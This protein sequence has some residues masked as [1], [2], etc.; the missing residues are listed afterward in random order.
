MFKPVIKKILNAI[1]ERIGLRLIKSSSVSMYE[2][3]VAEYQR[4]F[5]SGEDLPFLLSVPDTAIKE[6]LKFAPLSKSQIRQDLFV[7]IATDFKRDG[8][9]VEFG[10]TDGVSLS[11]SYLLETEFS[12][13]GILAE[14]ARMWHKKL[15]NN[16]KSHIST[17]CVWGDSGKKIEFVEASIPELSTT[18]VHLKSDSHATSR[19]ISNTYTVDTISLNDL[20]I[21]Y[22]APTI[23]DYLSI[24]TEGSE[25]LIL[26]KFNFL[27]WKF[28]VITVEHNFTEQR[29]LIQDL[30]MSNGYVRVYEDASRFDD[31]YLNRDLVETGRFINA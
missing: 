26:S 3:I 1:L 31:W 5:R 7:L 18:E 19:T 11:N 16:R 10:A 2:I 28:R 13:N 6:V 25:L 15:E 30:L 4:D 23:I 17:S 29:N 9:F 14:P 27:E 8:Y 12:W 24:D 21:K 22:N 20:L